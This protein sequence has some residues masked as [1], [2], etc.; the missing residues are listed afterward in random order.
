MALSYHQKVAFIS[1]M[2]EDLVVRHYR[3]L[4]YAVLS[5]DDNG[6]RKLLDLPVKSKAAD[7]IVQV[8]PHRLIV[9]E[10]K[11]KNIDDAFEQLRVTVD[12]VRRRL[13]QFQHIACKVFSAIAPPLGNAVDLSGAPAG[14]RAVRT[15]WHGF[16]GEWPLWTIHPGGQTELL[17][18]GSDPVNLIF[19]PFLS[20]KDI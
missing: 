1:L 18:I 14:Y 20:P 8:S 4:G 12:A 16:P 17:R 5:E 11:G 10:V 15:L 2:R 3:S 13:P 7:V 19:G 6:T 9:A